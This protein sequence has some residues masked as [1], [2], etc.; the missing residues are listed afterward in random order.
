MRNLRACFTYWRGISLFFTHRIGRRGTALLFFAFLDLVFA[1]S[2][3]R[4]LPDAQ[5]NTGTVFINH[6]APLWLWGLL[7]LAAGLL[8]LIYAFRSED[9]VA[10]AAAIAIKVLWGLVYALGGILVHIE[11]A[12]L[13]A[14][15][16][17]SMA[18]WV[19]IISTWPEPHRWHHPATPPR[20]TAGRHE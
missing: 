3:F 13:A 4:P 14:A 7:W 1:F 6:L 12:W 20:P 19:Y 15:I 16:W 11:R 9:R 8:C 10:F 2:L 18:G 5:R 17:L